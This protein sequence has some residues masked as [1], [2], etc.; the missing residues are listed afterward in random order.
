MLEKFLRQ[1][2]LLVLLY[3]WL[4]FV[5]S[6]TPFEQCR[7]RYNTQL[8]DFKIPKKPVYEKI[9]VFYSGVSMEECIT[10]VENMRWSVGLYCESS[11]FCG[12]GMDLKTNYERPTQP[13]ISSVTE[14]CD[15]LVNSQK[16]KCKN[17]LRT[18]YDIK[19]L[20]G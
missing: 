15:L 13:Q 16:T 3:L 14:I 18:I 6:R 5:C 19:I 20:P 17:V 11:L 8:C 2:R 10:K 9:D 4:Q 1:K 12:L 7:L